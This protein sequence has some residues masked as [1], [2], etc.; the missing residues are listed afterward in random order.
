MVIAVTN[1]V[2]AAVTRRP[3]MIRTL[4]RRTGEHGGDAHVAS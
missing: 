3:N 1:A 2:T 4:P